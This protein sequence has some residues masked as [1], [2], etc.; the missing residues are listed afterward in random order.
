MSTPTPEESF[1]R[2][3]DEEGGREELVEL[4]DE[5]QE[6]HDIAFGRLA[7]GFRT[8]AEQLVFGAVA[9]TLIDRVARRLWVLPPD[10]ELTVEER[11]RVFRA[12]IAAIDEVLHDR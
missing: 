1:Y 4:R 6:R 2:W 7:Q 5:I 11:L 10:N 9:Y 3:L 8:E 12:C